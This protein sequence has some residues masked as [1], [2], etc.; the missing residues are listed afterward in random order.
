[1][2][3]RL[4]LAFLIAVASCLAFTASAWA[5]PTTTLVFTPKTA[6]PGDTV[7][8]SIAGIVPNATYSFTIAGREISGTN[9]SSS[10]NGVSG[11]F[12]MP[13]L[14]S[15]QLTLTAHG[16]CSC[17]DSSD[18]PG[19][20]A[21]MEYL[22]PPPPASSGSPQGSDS[23]PA[24][25]VPANTSQQPK[26]SATKQAPAASPSH[27][28][29]APS[30]Q[31][32]GAGSVLGTEVAAPQPVKTPSDSAPQA[33]AKE[34]TGEASSS[35]SNR[36][37]DTIGGTTSVGPAKVPTLGLSAIALIL[38]VGLGLAGLAIYIFR[39]GPDPDAAVRDPAPT[40]PDPIEVELQQI[41]ADEMAR[42]LVS[43]LNL[44]EPTKVSSK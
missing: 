2:R 18:N 39:N 37:L 5:C 13:D 33:K 36:V 14:G 42:Q 41:I 31:G 29:A 22:P 27:P 20:S 3:S 17:P 6:G 21:S 19:L 34:R 1:M 9:T 16:S 11:T 8:Y 10:D 7:S 32:S 23:T 15:Q 30:A 38:I 24:P 26:T 40:G 12:T 4:P 25:A 28:A 44:G 43:D 35:V